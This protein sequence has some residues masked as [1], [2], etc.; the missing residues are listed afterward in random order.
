[1]C[2][3]CLLVISKTFIH[4]LINQFLF[5]AQQNGMQS[6]PLTIVKTNVWANDYFILSTN[7]IITVFPSKTKHTP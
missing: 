6:Q 2:G 4:Q 3:V 7:F 1:M 5:Q